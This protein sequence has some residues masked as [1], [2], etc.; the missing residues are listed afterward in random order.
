MKRIDPIDKALNALDELTDE[1]YAVVARIV[2]RRLKAI[3]P[4]QVPTKTRTRQKGAK[5]EEL[6]PVA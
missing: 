6:K 5:T 4:A 1:Q 3:Q 2:Q